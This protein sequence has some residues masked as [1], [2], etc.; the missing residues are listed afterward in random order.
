MNFL[1]HPL[2]TALALGACTWLSVANSRGLS[3]FHTVNPATWM[4][5]G[6]GGSGTGYTH[7]SHISHFS[8]K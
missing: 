3:F 7:G 4:N 2:Y 1:R 8:H 5:R 6:S